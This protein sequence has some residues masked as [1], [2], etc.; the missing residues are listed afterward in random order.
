MQ[1]VTIKVLLNITNE[2]LTRSILL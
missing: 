2:Q 1:L